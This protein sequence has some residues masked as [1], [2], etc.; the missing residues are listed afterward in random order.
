MKLLLALY[1]CDNFEIINIQGTQLPPVPQC[2][3]AK[4][5]SCM[6]KNQVFG[7]HTNILARGRSGKVRNMPPSTSVL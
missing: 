5:W 2:F 3:Q 6:Q 1:L 7:K 4:E